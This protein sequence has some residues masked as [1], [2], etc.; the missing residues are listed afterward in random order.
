[1]FTRE[2]VAREDLRVAVDI[3]WIWQLCGDP[4]DFLGRVPGAPEHPG[5]FSV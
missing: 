5:K 1:V 2:A 3:D 4:L